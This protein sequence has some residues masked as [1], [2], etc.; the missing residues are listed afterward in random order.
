MLSQ[1][2]VT[3]AEE[4]AATGSTTSHN[5]PQRHENRTAH[6]PK[7]WQHIG[8]LTDMSINPRA[9]V[10]R[11][12]AF[13]LAERTARTS[14]ALAIACSPA[15][16][17]QALLNSASNLAALRDERV[18]LVPGC[19]RSVAPH[20]YHSA[21]LF[22]E[23]SHRGMAERLASRQ[24]PTRRSPGVCPTGRR[25]GCRKRNLGI[26]TLALLLSQHSR[27]ST[28]SYSQLCLRGNDNMK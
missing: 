14:E 13:L 19:R 11:L 18:R 21:G 16:S 7:R 10:L 20:G 25:R 12:A 22:H 5:H 27:S 17:F 6:A 1:V 9:D 24:M 4:Y 26:R 8:Q 23:S 3:R 28:T 15:L 2:P